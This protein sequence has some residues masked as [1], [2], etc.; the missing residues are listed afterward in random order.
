[1]WQERY[2]ALY[3]IAYVI[4]LRWTEHYIS[5]NVRMGNLCL[6]LVPTGHDSSL[7]TASYRVSNQTHLITFTSKL[8]DTARADKH[9]KK[10]LVFFLKI[11]LFGEFKH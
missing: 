1:M 8:K 2:K 9:R 11:D 10:T 6:T 7:P 5:N 4:L 3:M